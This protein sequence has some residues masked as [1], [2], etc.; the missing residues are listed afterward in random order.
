MKRILNTLTVLILSLLLA[1][2]ALALDGEVVPPDVGRGGREDVGAQQR[3]DIFFS[4]RWLQYA[5]KQ[6]LMTESL[7]RS[8]FRPVRVGEQDDVVDDLGGVYVEVEAHDVI[9]EV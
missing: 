2:P 8:S 9:D 6:L 5:A 3:G 4:H 7:N 1:S